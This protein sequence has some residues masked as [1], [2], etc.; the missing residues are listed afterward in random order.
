[1]RSFIAFAV[2]GLAS[3]DLTSQE[4]ANCLVDGGEAV[5]DAAD[6]ALFIWAAYKRCGRSQMEVKCTVD[7]ASATESVNSMVN[8]ML[9][10]LKKCHVLDASECGM[11]AGKLTRAVAGLTAG[12]A[13]IIQKCPKAFHHT[14]PTAALPSFKTSQ[15]LC[16][17]D[18]KDTAKQ[19]MKITKEF[20]QVSKNCAKEDK[21]ACA[22]NALRII[23]GLA[24]IGEFVTGSIGHCT[25]V[26]ATS[27]NHES[28]LCAQAVSMV[29][30][31]TA[32]VAAASTDLS[33]KCVAP[34]PAPSPVNLNGGTVIMETQA[35]RLYEQ[36]GKSR[37]TASSTNM[38]LAAFLPVTAIVAFAGGRFYA[39]RRIR[40]EQSRNLMHDTE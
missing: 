36:G 11:A 2:L 29:T 22:S 21:H 23:G 38:V 14:V 6:A 26:N 9:K 12:G 4:I 32:K 31:H 5:D 10:A 37:I 30:H 13:D 7:I 35:N 25:K 3:A 8:V 34:A 16:L 19:L 18:V 33:A 24:A 28:A 39:N 17:V 27:G 15:A 40:T 1:M 20:M